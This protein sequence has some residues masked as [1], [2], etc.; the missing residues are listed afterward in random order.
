MILN[1]NNDENDREGNVGYVEAEAMGRY[2]EV[3]HTQIQREDIEIDRQINTV[4]EVEK[5]S[6]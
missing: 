5:P 2:C 3:C 4:G 1:I 6:K